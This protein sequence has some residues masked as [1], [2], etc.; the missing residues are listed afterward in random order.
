MRET[1]NAQANIFEEYSNHDYGV[2]LR[3]LSKNLDRHP[4]I[5]D[6]VAADLIDPSVSAV[7]RIR[8]GDLSNVYPIAGAP[9]T[10]SVMP[11]IHDP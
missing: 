6:P 7:G 10:Q 3:K 11:T 5:L 1:R 2:R 8:F 9:V 4:G